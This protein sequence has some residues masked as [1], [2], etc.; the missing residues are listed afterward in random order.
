MV[1]NRLQHRLIKLED[2]GWVKFDS[3]DPN[4]R[5]LRISGI[6]DVGCE[7]EIDFINEI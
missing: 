1:T 2:R 3:N 5:D 4:N 6:L 7:I